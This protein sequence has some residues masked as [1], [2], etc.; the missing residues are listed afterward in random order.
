MNRTY[1]MLDT[2]S[3]D[4][5]DVGMKNVEE[6]RRLAGEGMPASAIAERLGLSRQRVYQICEQNEIALPRYHR[7][8]ERRTG[9]PKS[10]VTTGGVQHAINHTVAGTIAELLAAADLMARGW[11]VFVPVVKSK[12]HDL[13]ACRDG[14][15][16]TF[17][18]RSAYRNAAGKL[19]FNKKADCASK[20]YALV[21]TGEPVTYE[22]QLP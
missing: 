6:I 5:Y 14:E 17:E 10:R 7:R 4:N 21:I 12:G 16:A 3:I 19:I 15:I 11:V 9:A 13:I 18:V 1:P 8:Y 2:V 22:P 20:Y